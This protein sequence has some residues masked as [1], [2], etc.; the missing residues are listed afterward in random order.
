MSVAVDTPA[1]LQEQM[2]DV[3]HNLLVV[4]AEITK[5]TAE[6][7]RATEVTYFSQ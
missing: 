6:C 4:K 2:E 7:S 3:K 1:D 5:I